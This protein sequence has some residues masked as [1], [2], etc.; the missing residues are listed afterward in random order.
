[1]TFDY[2]VF[3]DKNEASEN[4]ENATGL[5]DLGDRCLLRARHDKKEAC[6]NYRKQA[7]GQKYPLPSDFL[8]EPNHTS[9]LDPHAGALRLSPPP[10]QI[11]DGGGRPDAADDAHLFAL[12]VQGI[13]SWGW[14]A[15]LWRSARERCGG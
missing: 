9:L 3:L 11:D 5:V 4:P 1:M 10:A 7:T 6:H 8:L 2:Y 14:P 12:S 15:R 13:A